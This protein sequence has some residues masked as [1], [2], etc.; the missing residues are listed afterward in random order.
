MEKQEILTKLEPYL[1]ISNDNIFSATFYAFQSKKI[2]Y[3][4]NNNNPHLTLSYE[5]H[6]T[7]IPKH[8][9]VQAI[10]TILSFFKSKYLDNDDT[11]FCQYN[12]SNPKTVI[13]YIELQNLNF[14]EDSILNGTDENINSDSYKIESF[15]NEMYNVQH[16]ISRNDYKG[17]KYSALTLT[18]NDNETITLVNKAAPIFKAKGN[19]F[20]LD[21]DGDDNHGNLRPIEK[22]IIRLPYWPHLIIVDGFCFMIEYN[23]ESI[24]GFEQFNKKERDKTLTSLSNDLQF[25]GDSLTE[26]SKYANKGKNYNMFANFDNKY[27]NKI[28]EK[29]QHTLSLLKTVADI[30]LNPAGEIIITN[31]KEAHRFL[32]FIC[33]FVKQDVLTL[34]YEIANKTTAMP[35]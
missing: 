3:K 32:A 28:K 1:N 12:I 35:K 30:N 2:K 8:Q 21:Y 10:K 11:T 29:D 20:T 26:V 5:F 15:L 24:F 33:G 4:N 7:G 25:A 16:A 27:L 23:V 14:Q 19:F 9:V 31:E 22:S 13:D 6:D 34:D 17:W 18:N